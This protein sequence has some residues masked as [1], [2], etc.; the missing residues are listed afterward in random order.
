MLSDAQEDL[1]VDFFG[2]TVASAQINGCVYDVPHAEQGTGDTDASDAL[3]VPY[4]G[5]F[6]S[7]P[8]AALHVG[9]NVVDIGFTHTY[10]S[11]SSGM[12]R[13]RDPVDDRDYLYTDFEPYDQNR[14]FPS[15]DQPDLKAR[16]STRGERA[17]KL[18]GYIHYRRIEHRGARRQETLDLPAV[19]TDQYLYLCVACRGI[20]AL[21]SGSGRHS[22]KALRTGVHGG[23]H[24]SGRL[25]Q[26][27]QAGF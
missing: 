16:Y 9:R 19:C 27:D 11:D 8:A 22:V 23:V 13:F 14:L 25:V 3:K 2:G 7:L 20:P 18:A 24:V 5:F 26:S 10:S 1:T 12:Y 15:F 21:G 6:L 4:N 17:G